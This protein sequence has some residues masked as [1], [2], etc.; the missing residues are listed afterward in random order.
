MNRRNRRTADH[1]HA[2]HERWLVSYAD[3]ITLLFAFFV[4]MYAASRGNQTKILKLAQAIHVAFAEMGMFTPHA[5]QLNLVTVPPAASNAPS[6]DQSPLML[7]QRKLNA[8]MRPEIERNQLSLHL[9][10]EGLVVRMEELGFFDS[11]SAQV[12][13]DAMPVLARIAASVA[14]LPNDLRIQGYTDDVPIHNAQFA[15]NWQLST[16]RATELVRLFITSYHINPERLA[17]SGYAQYHP[18]ASNATAAGRQ[19]NRRVDLVVVAQRPPPPILPPA[20]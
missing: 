9:T 18:I 6:L 19:I 14:S 17:A 16:A 20:Q 10:R 13:P 5:A 8:E 1:P 4:V 2:N 15:S 12:R 3:F 11:G 7:L